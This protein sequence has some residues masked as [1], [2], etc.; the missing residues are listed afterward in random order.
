[1]DSIQFQISDKWKNSYS[2]VMNGKRI[3]S[4]M[5]CNEKVSVVEGYLLSE[6]YLKQNMK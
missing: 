5:N 6:K 4:V 3:N 2:L 1:M